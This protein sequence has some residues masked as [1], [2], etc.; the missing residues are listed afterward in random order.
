MV[1]TRSQSSLSAKRQSLSSF[2][3]RTPLSQMTRR[4]SGEK[5][6]MDTPPSLANTPDAAKRKVGGFAESIKKFRLSADL[7]SPTRRNIGSRRDSLTLAAIDDIVDS[8]NEKEN[9]AYAR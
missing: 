6:V 7:Q 1:T 3:P 2:T 5:F 9:V 4:L 8:E